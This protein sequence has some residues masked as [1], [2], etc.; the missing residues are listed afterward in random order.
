MDDSGC[1]VA[2]LITS[3]LADLR[4]H[5][6]TS[7]RKLQEDFK[8]PGALPRLRGRRNSGLVGGN[9]IQLRRSEIF[10]AI[11]VQKAASSVGAASVGQRLLVHSAVKQVHTAPTSG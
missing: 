6:T 10:I 1:I 11:A 7:A 4:A 5:T 2:L 8:K 9:R 3:K